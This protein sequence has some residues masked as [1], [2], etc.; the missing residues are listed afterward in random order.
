MQIEE[1]VRVFM[2]I[3]RPDVMRKQ[4]AIMQDMERV[5]RKID[6]IL[7]LIKEIFGRLEKKKKEDMRPT[8]VK[9]KK[10]KVEMLS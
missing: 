6:H 2:K 1:E 9:L 5:Y 3:T 4:M 7:K 10:K 8:K